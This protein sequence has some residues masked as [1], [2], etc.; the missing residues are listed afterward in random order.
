MCEN[1]S[2]SDYGDTILLKKSLNTNHG[3]VGTKKE[4]QNEGIPNTL[5]FSVVRLDNAIYVRK[6]ANSPSVL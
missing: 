2:I 6:T 4:I 1:R 3:T 5:F